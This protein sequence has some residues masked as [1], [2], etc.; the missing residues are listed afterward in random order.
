MAL[1]D[2]AVQ[3]GGVASGEII[4]HAEPRPHGIQVTG[5]DDGDWKSFRLQ[6]IGPAA[7]ATAIRIL[8]NGDTR[9]VRAGG[10]SG[11]RQQDRGKPRKEGPA[12][13]GFRVHGKTPAFTPF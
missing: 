6:M 4:R 5:L 13:A 1:H 2:K 3:L 8:V 10:G 7:A 11:R 12:T 9:L